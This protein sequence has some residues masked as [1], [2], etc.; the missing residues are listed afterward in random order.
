M[1]Q[2]KLI[3]GVWTHESGITVKCDVKQRAL[4]EKGC[5]VTGRVSRLNRRKPH[6]RRQHNT[7]GA[8]LQEQLLC[9]QLA[10]MLQRSLEFLALPG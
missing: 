9:H 10:V 3:L 7:V 2:S 1:Q 5:K 8:S 4:L 6:E